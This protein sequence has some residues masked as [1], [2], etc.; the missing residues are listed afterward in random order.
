[1]RERLQILDALARDGL[2]SAE[3]HTERRRELLREI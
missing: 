2:I 3:E 1:M